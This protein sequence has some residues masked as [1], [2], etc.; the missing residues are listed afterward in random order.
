V[1]PAGLTSSR[2][3]K[4][5]TACVCG[6]PGLFANC[7]LNELLAER[8]PHSVYVGE[9]WNGSGTLYD[10]SGN[11]RHAALTVGPSR[12]G[13]REGW[14]VTQWTLLIRVHEGGPHTVLT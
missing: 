6:T 11:G 14:A 4:G 1:C 7:R 13:Q 12:G 2:G 10:L 9:A 5:V 8:V 3:G